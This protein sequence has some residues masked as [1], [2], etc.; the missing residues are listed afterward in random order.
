MN[1]P[2]RLRIAFP[3]SEKVKYVFSTVWEGY[4]PVSIPHLI[5]IYQYPFFF[6]C[7]YTTMFQSEEKTL[8]QFKDVNSLTKQHSNRSI[9]PVTHA[10]NHI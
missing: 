1:I 9:R 7:N 10:Q 6:F 2:L 4:R 3:N 8:L 5:K